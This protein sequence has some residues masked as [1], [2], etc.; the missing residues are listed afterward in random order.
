LEP[1]IKDVSVNNIFVLKHVECKELLVTNIGTKLLYPVNGELRNSSCIK[2]FRRFYMSSNIILRTA[3]MS[4]LSTLFA[5][6]AF[7]LLTFGVANAQS[8]S[9]VSNPSGGVTAAS[10]VVEIRDEAIGPNFSQNTVTVKV[11]TSVIIINKSKETQTI[12]GENAVPFTLAPGKSVTL[13]TTAAPANLHLSLAN[14]HRA[15]LSINFVK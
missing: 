12:V 13:P 8:V 7:S 15:S 6:M 5:F 2:S 14:N 11:G 3:R 4:V 9:H 10:V 1:Y